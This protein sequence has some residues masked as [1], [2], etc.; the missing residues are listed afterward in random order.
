MRWWDNAVMNPKR[1]TADIA[2]EHIGRGVVYCPQHGPREDGVITSVGHG[3]GAMVFVRYRDDETS[4]A[5]R[6][7]DLMF[8]LD[9]N[10]RLVSG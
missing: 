6:P 5:I 1:L 8:L 3:L 10:N 7:V 2:R 9:E 4:K